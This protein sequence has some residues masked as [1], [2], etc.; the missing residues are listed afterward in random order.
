[1]AEATRPPERSDLLRL[2]AELNSLHAKYIVIGGLATF[3]AP[4]DRDSDTRL[5]ADR[6]AFRIWLAF[7]CAGGI[8][9]AS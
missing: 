1:M 5:P 6:V 2:C 9:I 7:L 8:W 3:F 4:Q